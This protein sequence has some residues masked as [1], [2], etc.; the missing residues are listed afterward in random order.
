SPEL[1]RLR[2]PIHGRAG[3]DAVPVSLKEFRGHVDSAIAAEQLIH[4]LRS[5]R[6]RGGSPRRTGKAVALKGRESCRAIYASRARKVILKVRNGL[7]VLYLR[8]IAT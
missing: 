4:V 1:E 7:H 2:D 8:G 6:I 5:R 3:G